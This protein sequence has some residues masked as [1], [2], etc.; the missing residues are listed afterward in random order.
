ML[1]HGFTK[2]G[3][4]F[5]RIL[6][7]PSLIAI[8]IVL[9][10]APGW[11]RGDPVDCNPCI[12][13]TDCDDGEICVDSHCVLAECEFD[14]DCPDGEICVGGRCEE[15][16]PCGDSPDCTA[17][18]SFCG[19]GVCNVE[20]QTCEVEPQ[21]ERAECRQSEDLCVLTDVCLGGECVAIP[22]CVPGCQLCDAG[23]CTSLCGNPFDSNDSGTTASDALFT[24]RVSVDLDTCELCL[25]DLTGDGIVTCSDAL[26]I[27]NA[28]V[29]L[30]V[31]LDCPLPGDTTTTTTI[32]T[33]T[34]STTTTSDTS[35]TTSTIVVMESRHSMW[36]RA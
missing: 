26:T 23:N 16:E 2:N 7:F 24:L 35:T 13:D 29:K 8:A 14:T 19:I 5:F 10:P 25:C 32:S 28:A 12:V 3:S 20:T 36:W 34:T 6:A 1:S 17:L 30:P 4:W 21:N 18:D 15:V 9:L 22:V 33:A 11:T 31:A 27:L